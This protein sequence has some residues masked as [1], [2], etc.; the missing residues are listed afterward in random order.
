MYTFVPNRRYSFTTLAP[1]VLG[2]SRTASKIKAILDY[3][4]AIKQD[5]VSQKARIVYP[6]LPSG[7][8]EDPTQY[9]YLLLESPDKRTEILAYE[10]IDSNSIT[11]AD[12]MTVSVTI[13]VATAEDAT[14]IRD[15]LTL[16]GYSGFTIK[17]QAVSA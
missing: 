13:P 12:V 8:E 3:S 2:G 11:T 16:M 4:M 9:T 5:A 7:T 15:T 14:K 10:W 6:L 17:T 1:S